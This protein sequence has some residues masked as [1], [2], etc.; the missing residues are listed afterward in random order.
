MVWGTNIPQ[1]VNLGQGWTAYYW[2]Y[3]TM[4]DPHWIRLTP[5]S[6]WPIKMVLRC[7]DRKNTGSYHCNICQSSFHWRWPSVFTSPNLLAYEAPARWKNSM[8]V[9]SL[10]RFWGKTPHHWLLKILRKWI[11][12][13]PGCLYE[14]SHQNL[15][16]SLKK[17]ADPNL[18]VS[19]RL[20]SVFPT[21]SNIFQHVPTLSQFFVGISNV[22]FFSAMINRWSPRKERPSGVMIVPAFDDRPSKLNH[23]DTGADLLVSFIYHLKCYHLYHKLIN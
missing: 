5:F 21:F 13:D 3:H 19:K 10:A 7:W 20:V 2:I 12:V 9:A 8:K 16:K 1:I 11:V 23:D 14:E 4:K 15:I 18:G 17:I 6:H 22:Q